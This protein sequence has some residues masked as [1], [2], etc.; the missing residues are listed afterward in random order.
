MKINVWTIVYLR[1]S[2]FFNFKLYHQCVCV[3]L[4]AF[5]VTSEN[6]ECNWCFHTVACEN[7][8]KIY[9]AVIKGMMNLQPLRCEM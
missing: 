2:F 3:Q 5:R 8:F 9:D 7:L 6:L 1:K 4:K